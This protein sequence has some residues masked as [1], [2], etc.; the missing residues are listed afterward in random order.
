M[1]Y[2]SLR[3]KTYSRVAVQLAQRWRRQDGG[4]QHLMRA[5]TCMQE[6][7][8]QNTVWCHSLGVA[9]VWF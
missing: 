1:P 6:R 3:S 5:C 2:L 8:G 7:S 9:G 4:L